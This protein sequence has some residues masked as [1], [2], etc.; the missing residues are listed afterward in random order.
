LKYSPRIVGGSF[1]CVQ[2]DLESLEDAPENVGGKF[3]CDNELL[4]GDNLY[5]IVNALLN[6]RKDKKYFEE[7]ALQTLIEY[8]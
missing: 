8:F 6:G 3:L 5:I 7:E 4:E 1:I 2:N